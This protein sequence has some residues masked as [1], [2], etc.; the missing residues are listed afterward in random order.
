MKINMPG[1]K[2][3]TV[4]FKSLDRGD[5]FLTVSGS[6]LLMK[7]DYNDSIHTNCVSLKRGYLG[8]VFDTDEVIPLNAE[9]NL[10]YV[11]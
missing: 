8:L 11:N 1:S 4:P 3:S 9:L 5:V 2:C 10:E 7:L 6:E